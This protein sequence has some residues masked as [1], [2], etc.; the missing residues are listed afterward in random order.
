MKTILSMLAVFTII[1][2]AAHAHPHY[3][4]QQPR[5]VIYQQPPYYYYQPQ[6]QVYYAPPPPP[7]YYRPQVP[8]YN[9]VYFGPSI[10]V[11]FNVGRSFI[12]INIR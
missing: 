2:T 8:C 6:P 9:N 12:G 7:V 11:G 1:N 10:G 4:Y 5:R 3:P